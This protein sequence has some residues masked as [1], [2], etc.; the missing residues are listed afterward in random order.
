MHLSHTHA[1]T[2]LIP[3]QSVFCI[4]QICAKLLL[5]LQNVLSKPLQLAVYNW[6]SS[7]LGGMI[8]ASS[9]FLVLFSCYSFI[10]KKI[11]GS[12]P[13]PEIISLLTLKA[14]GFVEL[15]CLCGTR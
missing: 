14:G 1:E 15:Q 9:S 11:K 4:L 13:F 10:K 6:A 8:F 3:F 5:R 7:Q 12:L 2:T